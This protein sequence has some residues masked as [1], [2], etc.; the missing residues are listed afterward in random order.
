MVVVLLKGLMTLF[1]HFLF[2]LG[3]AFPV[4]VGHAGTALGRDGGTQ[5]RGE[6]L[7]PTAP[8]WHPPGSLGCSVSQP[9]GHLAAVCSAWGIL[10][11]LRCLCPGG[12]K[13]QG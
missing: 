9:S 2:L 7:A 13:S 6:A 5:G 12:R 3:V 4:V 8:C 10:K 11:L 1:H